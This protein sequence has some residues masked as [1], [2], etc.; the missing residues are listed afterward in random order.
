MIRR[1]PRSTRTDTLFPYTTLFRSADHEIVQAVR[2]LD[3]HD[4]PEDRLAA[5]L[6]Q[7]LRPDRA[8]LADPGAV[9]PGQDDDLHGS[10]PCVRIGEMPASSASCG[11][12]PG[13]ALP[14]PGAPTKLLIGARCP[15]SREYSSMCRST[16]ERMSKVLSDFSPPLRPSAGLRPPSSRH[17]AMPRARPSN[18][19]F[20]AMSPFPLCPTR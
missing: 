6:D 15:R 8:L 13:L 12:S 19:S 4:V 2:R 10:P 1:P 3:L 9:A 11:H 14:S 16:I 18:S 7:R 17:Q 20:S 5:D